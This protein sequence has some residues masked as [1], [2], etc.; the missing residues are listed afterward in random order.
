M[1]RFRHL[2]DQ[3]A[4]A[5]CDLDGVK[6]IR[7]AGLIV[8][9]QATLARPKRRKGIPQGTPISAALANVYMLHFDKRINDA[10]KPL[11]GIYRRYSDDMIVVCIKRQKEVYRY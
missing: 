2:K 4:I 6:N 7:H 3:R 5:F 10:V 1:K 8:G 11:K 9:N